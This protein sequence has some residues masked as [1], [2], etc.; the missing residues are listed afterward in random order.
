MVRVQLN[1]LLSKQFIQKLGCKR[2]R[3]TGFGT[4][5]KADNSYVKFLA[6]ILKLV[7]LL[8]YP[9]EITWI[10]R[11]PSLRW[12]GAMHAKQRVV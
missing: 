10:F 4:L 3:V 12:L 7:D 8:S 6:V 9:I 1:G 5:R 2:S 11:G